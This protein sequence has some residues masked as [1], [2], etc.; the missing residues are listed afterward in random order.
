M[1]SNLVAMASTLIACAFAFYCYFT[2]FPVWTSPWQVLGALTQG[3]DKGA[4]IHLTV[5]SSTSFQQILVTLVSE[6]KTCHTSTIIDFRQ[7]LIKAQ[8]NIRAVQSIFPNH[9]TCLKYAFQLLGQPYGSPLNLRQWRLQGLPRYRWSAPDFVLPRAITAENKTNLN[10]KQMPTLRMHCECIVCTLC[11]CFLSGRT[12]DWAPSFE[13]KRHKWSRKR[14]SIL[15]SSCSTM[16]ENSYVQCFSRSTFLILFGCTQLGWLHWAWQSTRCGKQRWRTRCKSLGPYE[17]S[18]ITH[19]S[20][21]MATS[22]L[23]KG[24]FSLRV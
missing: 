22:V 18:R 1:A 16:P 5:K 4:E 3:I 23:G 14:S 15:E 13:A 20:D 12:C 19:A 21:D 6:E 24:R 8:S 11:I 17:W 10:T 9:S 2:G 7:C